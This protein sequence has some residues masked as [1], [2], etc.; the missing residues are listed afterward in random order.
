MAK[1]I[2]KFCD[3]LNTL[4][5][6]HLDENGEADLDE[7]LDDVNVD[8]LTSDKVAIYY[9]MIAYLESNESN[10]MLDDTQINRLLNKKGYSI[11]IEVVLMYHYAVYTRCCELKVATD[12]SNFSLD[13]FWEIF[14][15]VDKIYFDGKLERELQNNKIQLLASFKDNELI[16]ALRQ[17]EQ[18]WNTETVKLN[19][20]MVSKNIFRMNRL[21]AL[22]TEIGYITSI[23]FHV[24]F[25]G[26]KS[27]SE[28]EY[29]VFGTSDG[30]IQPPPGSDRRK[31]IHKR[32][33]R[34]SKDKKD[35]END[36]ENEEKEGKDSLTKQD[37]MNL[38]SEYPDSKESKEE[39]AILAIREK[40]TES[41]HFKKERRFS[42]VDHPHYGTK[43][44]LLTPIGDYFR[45]NNG[46]VDGPI[47]DD[48]VVERAI[49]TKE[50]IYDEWTDFS[51]MGNSDCIIRRT[52]NAYI[53]GK[54]QL[55]HVIDDDDDDGDEYRKYNRM[56]TGY[57]NDNGVCKSTIIPSSVIFKLNWFTT[58]DLLRFYDVCPV[59]LGKS[60]CYIEPS[61]FAWFEMKDGKF[62][63]KIINVTPKGNYRVLY[64]D[65]EG[66]YVDRT[67]RKKNI[68]KGEPTIREIYDNLGEEGLLM[69]IHPIIM[70]MEYNSGIRY[71]STVHRGISAYIL[72]RGKASEKSNT[73]PGIVF[74]YDE[75]NG[76]YFIDHGKH[77]LGKILSSIPDQTAADTLFDYLTKLRDGEKGRQ[78]EERKKERMRREQQLKAEQYDQK[79]N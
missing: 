8:Q 27:R 55:F 11:P 20:L 39:K 25:G 38:L 17:V 13:I 43:V 46:D 1:Y 69:G 79:R 41:G 32:V 23:M 67:I 4:W 56:V 63:G 29:I 9:M 37:Y 7:A 44:G 22:I 64:K 35:N 70:N 61:E 68:K 19:R 15:L 10:P 30:K 76:E 28:I 42:W 72:V 48:K 18:G 21:D 65:S 3:T 14:R 52:Y 78:R 59:E 26:K 73:V 57:Y 62:L 34:A 33:E 54:R 36:E 71:F 60:R 74:G 31:Y 77:H 12:L 75:A 66:S 24:A 47:I 5:L 16:V 50:E 58:D 2:R 51:D 53:D 49:P 40:M 6:T 45:L